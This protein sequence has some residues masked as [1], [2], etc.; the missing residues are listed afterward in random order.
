MKHVLWNIT[1]NENTIDILFY[2]IVDYSYFL[3]DYNNIIIIQFKI[4]YNYEICMFS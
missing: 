4:V 1:D 3:M 2:D